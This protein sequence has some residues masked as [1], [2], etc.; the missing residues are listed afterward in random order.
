MHLEPTTKEGFLGK[1]GL[2]DIR[3]VIGHGGMGIVY[4]GVDPTLNRTVAVKVLLPHLLGDAA[5]KE[6][7]VR[8]A[9]AVAAL[10]HANVVTIH[11]I[12]E[13]DG[14]PYLV[15][16]YVAGESLADLLNR[17]KQLPADEIARIGAQVARG[18]AAAHAVGLVHRDIKPGNVLIEAGTGHVRIADFGLAKAIGGETIT[19]AGTLP[20]TPA[21]MSPEQV[22][23]LA[24]DAR[25]DLFS[26]GVLLYQ[27]V[28]GALPF[29]ADS[30]FVILDK[31]RNEKEKRLAQLDPSL[32]AWF[33]SIVE[34][35]LEKN[36]DQRVPTAAAVAEALEQRTTLRGAR[37][38]WL[39]WAIAACAMGA[40]LIAGYFV[41]DALRTPTPIPTPPERPGPIA[42]AADPLPFGIVDRTGRFPSLEAA[43]LSAKDGDV[44]EVHANGPFRTPKIE[45]VGTRLTIR[46]AAGSRPVFMPQDV[47][48]PP[49]QWITSDSELSLSGLD[50]DWPVS[51]KTSDAEVAADTAVIAARDRLHLT[52][53]RIV[54]GNRTACATSNGAITVDG[55]HLITDR[56]GGRC[57][58]WHDNTDLR[59]SQ[60]ALEGKFGLIV[61][62][63]LPRRGRRSRSTIARSERISPCCSSVCRSTNPPC[64]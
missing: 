48:N 49:L 42:P 12:A 41:Q 58:V 9:K 55:C 38:R 5:A 8:E 13:T 26:L 21:Y 40:L 37:S 20:G 22:S 6:R 33:C 10:S 23:G 7:F 36:P 18:L 29:A 27:G 61:A 51:A 4:E 60:S 54:S 52:R 30:P 59:I 56:R 57:V 15:L 47:D 31:I 50:V 16:Q 25:S 28:T 44:I 32:P 17:E 19:G 24:V 2:I 43:V 35:L 64:R 39:G 14:V 62:P 46:A 53:C 63:G 45:I 11:A 34:R 1:L 3:R